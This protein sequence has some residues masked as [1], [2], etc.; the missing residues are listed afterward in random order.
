MNSI[1]VSELQALT[2]LVQTEFQTFLAAPVDRDRRVSADTT[3]RSEGPASDG[4]DRSRGAIPDRETVGFS[5][6]PLQV[7]LRSKWKPLFF[8]P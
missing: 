5:L 7:I 2:L 8:N 4:Y 6:T 1:S 3:S